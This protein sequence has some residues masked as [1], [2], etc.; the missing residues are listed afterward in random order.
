MV[1]ELRNQILMIDADQL[2]NYT[3]M[4]TARKYATATGHQGMLIITGGVDN[5]RKILSS[6]ELYDST[7]GQWY[8]S[9]NLPQ[10][11]Y[12]SQSVIVDNILYL[13]GGVNKDGNYSPAVHWILCQD[14]S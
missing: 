4:I 5:K 1:R 10:P 8:V 6:T 7:N 11:H 13:F 3:K 9:N 2:K 12:W 14:T